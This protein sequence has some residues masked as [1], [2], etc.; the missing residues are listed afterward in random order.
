LPPL[1]VIGETTRVRG[2]ALCGATVLPA[3]TDAGV[4]ERW[5]NL[6]TDVA[7]VV[8]TPSAREALTD[9]LAE[10]GDTPLVVTM[11]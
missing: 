7:V 2:Y 9:A 10:L 8:L 11:P 1:V 5:A 4:R 3:D 6:P